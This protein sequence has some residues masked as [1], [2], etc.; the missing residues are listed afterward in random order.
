MA[1]MPGANWLVSEITAIVAGQPARV[2]GHVGL[3]I[4][5]ADLFLTLDQELDV[6]GKP[7]VAL[8]QASAALRWVNIWPLSSVAPRA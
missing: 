4:D 7:P 1:G 8:S 2:L 5:P 3:E 6:D